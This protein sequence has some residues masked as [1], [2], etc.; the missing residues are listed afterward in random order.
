M[1]LVVACKDD[2]L[3][4]AHNVATFSYS[5]MTVPL[6]Y[7]VTKQG[8]VMSMN[9]GAYGFINYLNGKESGVKGLHHKPN[10]MLLTLCGDVYLI[11]A[12][13]QDGKLKDGEDAM[14]HARPFPV[15]K[16]VIWSNCEHQSMNERADSALR[17][18]KTAK[19]AI[20][21]MIKADVWMAKNLEAFYIPDLL[22]RI[23][24]IHK[25]KFPDHE[26]YK[27]AK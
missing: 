13:L 1:S 10:A 7:W 2:H 19:E 21:L 6:E 4:F 12:R 26:L 20:E 15:G 25:E 24:Q 8:L 14:A 27:E 16:G 17:L 23:N 9:L 18:T 5:T 22:K 3:I 11:E